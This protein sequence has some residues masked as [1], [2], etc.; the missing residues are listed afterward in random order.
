VARLAGRVAGV[1]RVPGMRVVRERLA[2]QGHLRQV[3]LAA[4]GVLEAQAESLSQT[5]Q[6]RPAH[7]DLVEQI[8]ALYEHTAPTPGEA[9]SEL[10]Q[11][12]L[13]LRS[14]AVWFLV[15]LGDNTAQAIRL[16]GPLLADQEQILGPDHPDT[17]ISRGNLALAYQEAGRTAEA[18]GLYE[19]T[20]TD[21]GRIF[22]PDHPNTLQARN[23]LANAYQAAGR[24]DEAEALR[25]R[26]ER[27]R[28]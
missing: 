22:G 21:M 5:W 6:D 28:D 20:L 24:R 19:R 16:A 25:H 12:M 7:R 23:N 11:A 27:D 8:R 1:P 3:C 18:I 14:Q 2:H 9:G 4:A 10:T 17:L 26:A 15:E 13:R